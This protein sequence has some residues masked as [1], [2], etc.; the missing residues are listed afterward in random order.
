M[1]T[2]T[3][4]PA[5]FTDGRCW[6]CHPATEIGYSADYRAG[7]A[8]PAGLSD[9]ERA[10]LAKELI[11]GKLEELIAEQL[12]LLDPEPDR[13]GLA[14][15]PRR[16]AAM[17]AE[18]TAGY[19]TRPFELTT[20]ASDGADEMVVMSG[21]RF[22]SLC[23]HHLIP[24]MGHATVGYIPS[25]AGRLIGLSK[26]PRLVAHFSRRLQLQERLTEQIAEALEDA[27]TSSDGSFE[28]ALGVGVLIR[29]RH[30][31]V[32]MRGVRATSVDTTTSKLTGLM[33]SDE[34]ARAEFLDLARANGHGPA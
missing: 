4:E 6:Q 32:E 27:L 3:H 1:T 25:P 29:A 26:I 2:C 18:L 12:R 24:F 15:T 19:S 5:G 9:A 10:E 14:D 30:L 28:P 23:E 31:C 22:Y 7:R 21:I 34:K 16:V 8:A 11:A 20:F 13:P 33:K 17:L